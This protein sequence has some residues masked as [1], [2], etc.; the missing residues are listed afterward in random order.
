MRRCRPVRKLLGCDPGTPQSL[1][2]GVDCGIERITLDDGERSA[3]CGSVIR[4]GSAYR[5]HAFELRIDSGCISAVRRRSVGTKS[6]KPIYFA[7]QLNRYDVAVKP[8]WQVIKGR[9]T[10]RK[11]AVA[12]EAAIQTGAAV[13]PRQRSAVRWVEVDERGAGQ[14]VDNFVLRLCPG[15]PKTRLYRA[16][17]KGEIRVNKGRAKPQQRL[18]AGDQVRLPPLEAAAAAPPAVAPPGWQQRIEAAIVFEDE[19][20]IA[21]AKPA[22]LAVHGGSGLSFG[23]I[24]TLRA[25]FPAQRFLELVH[26]LDR[27]TSGLILVAK[28]PAALR[29]LHE[30][31]RRRGGI[32]KRYR[33]LAFGRWPR[34]LRQVEAPLE[35]LESRTAERR[36]RV[37][38]G[39]KPSLTEFRLLE[40]FRDC[41]LLE[42]R[43]ITG[44]THQIRVHAQHAGHPLIG[45]DRYS[46]ER[47]DQLT[48]ELQARR[49]FLHAQRLRF[50]LDGRD[51]DL[52]APLDEELD[53]L[54][55]RARQPSAD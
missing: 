23:L 5:S 50:R 49:L 13:S 18:F 16:L 31:L 46:D 20:L 19:Q 29:A 34:A 22:G 52:E 40:A 15:V 14:R 33:A 11:R 24:E 37:A 12:T 2:T 44:R 38:T 10:Q 30:L 42:A 48:A 26:R 28:R 21:V 4:A 51:Y 36:M 54:L 6:A 3:L 17:R 53:A 8:K 43:P 35:K 39:G 27:E 1:T 32:D 7:A 45:D 55:L 9:M 41:S 25:M 47:A